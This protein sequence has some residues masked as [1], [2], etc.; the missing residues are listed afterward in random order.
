MRD[1]V[2]LDEEFGLYPNGNRG[3]IKEY[4]RLLLPMVIQKKKNPN[5]IKITLTYGIVEEM[6]N[7]KPRT[8]F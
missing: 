7:M 3:F 2:R 5:K 6:D 1:L 4:K 8:N